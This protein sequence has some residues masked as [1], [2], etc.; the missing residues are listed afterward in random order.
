MNSYSRPHPASVCLFHS[1]SLQGR[2]LPSSLLYSL[3]AQTLTP[4]SVVSSDA[5]QSAVQLRA[6]VVI[7]RLDQSPSTAVFFESVILSVLFNLLLV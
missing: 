3:G 4:E 2:T 6:S 5:E 7:V 1:A